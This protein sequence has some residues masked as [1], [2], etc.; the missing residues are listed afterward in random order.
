MNLLDAL[1]LPGPDEVPSACL[2]N[3]QAWIAGEQAR[4]ED[5]RI[6]K[7]LRHKPQNLD[8]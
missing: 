5:I 8:I 2:L 7:P 1:R 6:L 3:L 4:I